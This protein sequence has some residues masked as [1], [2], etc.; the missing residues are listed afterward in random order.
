MNW[1]ISEELKTA[2]PNIISVDRPVSTGDVIIP[3]PSPLRG[4]GSP[5]PEGA[6]LI[7]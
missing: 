7:D 3:D 2:F 6:I 5:P 4:L 1:G